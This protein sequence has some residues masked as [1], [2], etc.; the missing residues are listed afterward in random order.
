MR[1]AVAH[2]HED[3]T[4]TVEHGELSIRPQS[5]EERG[6][7]GMGCNAAAVGFLEQDC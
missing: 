3:L 1:N 6:H 2:V 4:A 5:I 7:T